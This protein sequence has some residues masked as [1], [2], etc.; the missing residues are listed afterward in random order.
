MMTEVGRVLV[1]IL[2]TGYA[3]V[4]STIAIAGL[5]LAGGWPVWLAIYLVLR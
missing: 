1:F 2:L 4:G 5:L 3:I